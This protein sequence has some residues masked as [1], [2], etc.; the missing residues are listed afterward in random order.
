[1]TVCQVAVSL[2]L[3]FAA[4]QFI[5]SLRNLRGANPGVDVDGAATIKTFHG[6]QNLSNWWPFVKQAI[7][8]IEA[9]PGVD[10]VGAA[11][12]VPFS[13]F[14]GHGCTQQG[15]DEPAVHQ[16]VEAFE[17]TYCAAQAVATPGYF[18]AV[19][20]PMIQGR[21]FTFADLD[22][23]SEGVVV[24]SSTFAERFW[25]GE[26]PIGKRVSPYGGSI[27]WYRVIGVVGDVYRSSVEE[28]PQNLIYYPLAPVPGGAGWYFSGIDFVIRTGTG[29]PA[30]VMPPVRALINDID[31]TVAVGEAWTMPELVDRSMERMRFTLALVLAAA[32]IAL[33]LAVVGLYGVLAHLV[34]MRSGEIGLR[35]ALGARPD[36]VRRM[37]VASSMKLVAAGVLIGLACC[38]AASVTLR[39]FL[40]GIAPTDALGYA[41]A[42]LLVTAVTLA[43]SWF[44]TRRAA[45]VTPM[46]ALRTE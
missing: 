23:P 6:E 20:I 18:R 24:V 16:R 11:T 34:A 21:G 5:E 1:M 46:D 12:A 28:K 44:A 19:G 4:A 14:I 17:L 30:A 38:I 26:S 40:F 37:V 42:A 31:P 3:I 33:G 35:V 9:L 36:R 7:Q 25:P 29:A 2:V 32:C 45:R 10:V 41:A 15:F 39:G 13:R 22:N 27:Y 8:S 43:G